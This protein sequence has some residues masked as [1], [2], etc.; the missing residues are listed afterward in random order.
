MPQPAII[1]ILWHDDELDSNRAAYVAPWR[2]WFDRNAPK[3]GAAMQYTATLAQFA[4]A[5]RS[6]GPTIDLLVIDVMLKR[7]REQDFS[8]LGFARE[9]LLRM[10]AGAQVAGLLR[11]S[12]FDGTRPDWLRRYRRT[13]VVLL[14]STSTVMDLLKKYVDGDS[15]E[16]VFAVVKTLNVSATGPVDVDSGFASAMKELIDSIATQKQH[17]EGDV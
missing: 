7:E 12:G 4:Q 14:S 8:I 11:N 6:D 10:D 5:L 17:V 3:L 16:S 15:R 9:K 13:P 1:R 2:K